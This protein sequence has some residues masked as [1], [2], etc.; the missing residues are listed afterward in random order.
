MPR[1]NLRIAKKILEGEG[2]FVEDGKLIKD[3]KEFAFEFLIVSPSVEKIALAFQKT[4]ALESSHQS[5]H[6]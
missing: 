4:F 2:W 3:G 1:D 5:L 6:I